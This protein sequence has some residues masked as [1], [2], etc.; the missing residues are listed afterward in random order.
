MKKIIITLAVLLLA[1]PAMASVDIVLTPDNG[2]NTVTVSFTTSGEAELVRALALDIQ[3]SDPNVWIE[4]INCVPGVNKGYNISPTNVVISAGGVMSDPESDECAAV[5]DDNSL[6][7]EQGS[8]YVGLPSG[9]N[10]PNEGDLFIITLGGC[11]LDV[12]GDVAITISENVLRG[13]VVMEDV[14]NPGT[15]NLTGCSVGIGECPPEGCLCFGDISGPLGVP[16][17]AVSINDLTSMLSMLT[18]QEPYKSNTPTY[19]GPI[20]LD[21]E[22]ADISGPLGVPDGFLSINDLTSLLS[23]LT[24]TEPYKSNTPT[25]LGPCLAD[26]NP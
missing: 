12:S 5:V 9:P 13:K 14:S 23:V 17:D 8:L 15:V 22:C 21:W 18:G 6:T 20:P 1:A 24:G 19:L 3:F 2:A 25:Y 4:D 11:T 10:A 7:S 16:D 26:P